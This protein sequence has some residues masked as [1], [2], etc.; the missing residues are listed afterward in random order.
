[1]DDG[2]SA[3]DSTVAPTGPGASTPRALSPRPLTQR[4]MPRALPR[5]RS[6]ATW[7]PLLHPRAMVLTVAPVIVALAYLAAVGAH[8]A[9][10]IGLAAVLAV[11]LA[12]AG[13]R[14]LEAY[15]EHEYRF[16]GRQASAAFVSTLV[17][18]GIY[19]LDALRVACVLL[20]LSAAAAIPL[21][22]SGGSVVLLLG[23]LG[24]ALALLYSMTPYALKRYPAG[25]AIV[26]VLLGPSI[27]PLTILAQRQA[28]TVSALLLGGALGFLALAIVLAAHLRDQEA[29]RNQGRVTL[30][31]L[32]GTRSLALACVG[33]A[34]LAYLLVA[35]VALPRG[36]PHLA[37]LAFLSLPAAVVPLSG[38]LVSEASASRALVVRQL[39][40]VY[41]LFALGLALGLVITGWW[42]RL[43]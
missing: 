28:L 38:I 17:S 21:V 1:M 10:L 12:Q 24:I 31:T 36:A 16:V 40:R 26:F 42:L 20:A 18:A 33:C 29:D 27:V 30:V 35:I 32:L 37:L 14:V 23:L 34:G 11:G 43:A 6:L 9:P 8:I 39:V 2:V 19:P 4:A 3:G 22:L 13:M 7:V 5:S 15:L 25:D 41:L